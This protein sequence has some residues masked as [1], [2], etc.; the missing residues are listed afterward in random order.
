MKDCRPLS[1]MRAVAESLVATLA[2]FCERIEVAG[3]IRRER[4]TVG[5]VELVAVPRFVA[6]SSDM[7]GNEDALNR[8]AREQLTAGTWAPRLDKNGRAATGARYKRLLVDGIPL[9]LFSVLPPAQFGMILLIR[10][11]SA[12]FSHRFM[13]ELPAGL[14][15]RD[16]GL[17]RDG[18]LIETPE[19]R[20][21]FAAVGLPFVEPAGR[22]R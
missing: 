19:E 7:F 15:A 14:R 11:G 4:P 1:E 12:D 20:D 13:A 17:Y 21:I 5:D 10:T 2:A 16:G 22:E 6:S 3:S 9:D 18:R 8:F